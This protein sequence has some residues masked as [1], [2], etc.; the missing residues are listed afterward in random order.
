MLVNCG[1]YVFSLRNP[2]KAKAEEDTGYS[3]GRWREETQA[4][5]MFI[6]T[7]TTSGR[8]SMVFTGTAVKKGNQK[9]WPD[10]PERTRTA[11]KALIEKRLEGRS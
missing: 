4:C 7:Y 10:L 2:C 5:G 8:N 3:E 1:N 6:W 11:I 9:A